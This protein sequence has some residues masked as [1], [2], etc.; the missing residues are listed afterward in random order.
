MLKTE[1]VPLSERLVGFLCQSPDG[2]DADAD[3]PFWEIVIGEIRNDW[4][5]STPMEMPMKICCGQCDDDQ[6]TPLIQV[7]RKID[8]HLASYIADEFNK[9]FLA[10]GSR[11]WLVIF[12]DGESPLS[13]LHFTENYQ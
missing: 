3:G 6:W 13:E 10:E 7:G 12:L 4:A 11:H 1:A 2:L 5:P 9:K 8:L